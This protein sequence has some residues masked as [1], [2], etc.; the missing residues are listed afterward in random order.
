MGVSIQFTHI[1]KSKYNFV[2]IIMSAMRATRP[3]H[4]ILLNDTHIT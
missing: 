3:S 4:P 2:C 1:L